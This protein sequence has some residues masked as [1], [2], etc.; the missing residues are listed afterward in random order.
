M[1]VYAVALITIHDRE[2][3]ARYGQ[4]FMEIFERHSGRLLAVDEAPS[5][6][7]GEWPWTR[8]VLLEFPDRAALDAWYH[9]ADYQALAQHRHQGSDAAI[10]VL[11]GLDQT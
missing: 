8:T 2:A 11:Q 3:Y 7:E 9:S 1:G 4:G 10:A 6:L 5:V